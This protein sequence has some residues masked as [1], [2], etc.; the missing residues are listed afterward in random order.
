MNI[1]NLPPEVDPNNILDDVD[2]EKAN[3]ESTEENIQILID[4]GQKEFN[5]LD[6]PLSE[7]LTEIFEILMPGNG[8]I[9]TILWASAIATVQGNPNM[10]I[11]TGNPGEGKTILMDYILDFIPER[12]ILRMNDLTESGLFQTA[13][14]KGIYY[15]DK[16]IVYLGD[17][18]DKKGFEK[19]LTA[20]KILRTLQT[21]GYF[22]R[23]ISEK[24]KSED[25][26]VVWEALEQ[27]L[28]GKPA[29]WFSTVREDG[30][31][32]DK[33]RSIVC[34][35]N[36]EKEKEIKYIIQHIKNPKSRT[37]KTIRDTIGHWKPILHSIFEYLASKEINVIIPWD[38]SEMDYKFRD[39][40]RLVTLA[41]LLAIINLPYHDTYNEYILASE[42]D[43][44]TI[45][46]FLKEGNADLSAVVMK[47]LN[48]LYKTYKGNDFTRMDAVLT[49]PDTYPADGTGT[50][51]IYRD[52]LKPAVKAGFIQEDKEGRQ[53]IYNFT[54][55]PTEIKFTLN[56]PEIDWDQIIYE[57]G[58]DKGYPAIP[59]T[60]DDKNM[61]GE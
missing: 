31:A 52:I 28:M 18:G 10:G 3:E 33:D 40:D 42:F 39:I 12:H 48:I 45:A 35:T 8:E 51:N 61:D 17:L 13:N 37:G 41:G 46:K 34:T 49:F 4:R 30:D 29:M 2:Y 23:T 50:A 20:R 9:S 25:N 56:L 58:E 44:I 60:F 53:F 27:I 22:A 16:K 26:L 15:L 19:T 59:M 5:K 43:I 6:K 32:Q 7:Q 38:L 1:L 11:I 24:S 21:D 47:R 54:Q 36:L 55:S 57:Y 14:I